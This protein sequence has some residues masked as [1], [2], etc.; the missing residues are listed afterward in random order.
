MNVECRW[1]V[2]TKPWADLPAGE[3]GAL[4]ADMGF[5]GA[6]LAVRPGAHV[7]PATARAQ[8]PRYVN[9]LRR[10]DVE[11]VSIA[12]T[13][14]ESSFAACAEAGVPLIRI[15]APLVSEGY[16]ASVEGLRRTLKDVADMSARYGVGVGVQPHFGPFVSTVVGVLDVLRDLPTADFSLIWDAAHDALTGEDPRSTLPLARERL[17]VVNLKNAHYRRSPDRRS[18]GWSSYTPWFGQATTG[19]ADWA[20]VLATL[21]LMG[22]TGPLCLSAQYSEAVGPRAPEIAARLVRDDLAYAK[23]LVPAEDPMNTPN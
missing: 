9:E 22:W 19:M 13:V 12:S 20:R 14:E 8:L 5:S 3:L 1:A 6:E 11:V 18:D 21:D 7:T 15:M 4:V 17:S 16:R 23:K 10:S 2:F